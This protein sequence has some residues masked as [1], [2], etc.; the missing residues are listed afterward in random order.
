MGVPFICAFL[1][2]LNFSNLVIHIST[3][4]GRTMGAFIFPF[5]MF[6]NH[7]HLTLQYETKRQIVSAGED[8]EKLGHLYIVGG[9]VKWWNNLKSGSKVSQNF[10]HRVTA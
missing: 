1:H 6:K 3:F 9:N 4:T 2:S 5:S 8:A 10:K 7:F